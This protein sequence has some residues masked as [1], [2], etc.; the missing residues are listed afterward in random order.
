MMVRTVGRELT[1]D[2][3][4]VQNNVAILR[5]WILH[6][7]P[8]WP[9]DDSRASFAKAGGKPDFRFC[10]SAVFW[11]SWTRN[12]ELAGA[13]IH[14]KNN[15]GENDLHKVTVNSALIIATTPPSDS[16]RKRI[17]GIDWPGYYRTYHGMN[18][19]GLVMVAQASY[20]VPD[21]DAANILDY[22]LLYRE[23]L[24]GTSSI[25]GVVKLWATLPATR[26]VGFN[27]PI[28]TPYRP[29]QADYPSSTYETDSYGG[30]L[31]TP[32]DFAPADPCGI[33]TTNNYYAYQGTAPYQAAVGK[34]HGYHSTVEDHDYRFR[35]ML[36]LI[37]QYKD[38]NRTVGTREVIELLRAASTSKEYSGTTEFSIIWYP[39]SM[40][41]ALAKEDLVRKILDAP[42]TIYNRFT[43]D[44][45]LR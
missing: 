19:D 17:I 40:E 13:L 8:Y 15:D 41:F 20:S 14:E 32:L 6:A 24:Q 38:Q 16:C 4:T 36:S 12:N 22:T 2:D 25:A 11:G 29:G 26:A 5:Y 18:E 10:T 1:R 27:T 33:L 44:E 35:D 45:V 43:F 28:S 21:W 30:T 9:L 42:F 7:K 3:L 37:A 23:A 31:R 34:V 39:N